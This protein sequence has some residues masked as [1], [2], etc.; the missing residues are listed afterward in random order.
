[1]T[2]KKSDR[3]PSN[4]R[5]LNISM[6]GPKVGKARLAAADLAEII[7]QTQRALK[8][9]GQV[10]YGESS[11]GKGRKRR[12][13][14]E[15]CELFLVGWHSGSAVAELELRETPA[16][17]SL[18]DSIGE[19][20]LNAFVNG[21]DVIAKGSARGSSLP[22]GFDPGVLQTCDA[23]GKVL[24]H[25]VETIR[26]EARN[27]HPVS[28]ITFDAPLWTKVRELLGQSVDVSSVTKTGR[29][30]ELN[31]HGALTGKLWEPDGTK[32]VCYFKPEH[33]DLLSD[34]WMRSVKLAGQAII[35]EGKEHT[36]NVESLIVLEKELADVSGSTLA[37]PFWKSLSLEELAD[38]QGV[39][40]ITDLN[41]LSALWPADDDADALLAHVLSERRARGNIADQGD[42][43]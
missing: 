12:D 13:I 35:E 25:G 2:S 28:T 21:M 37:A 39:A 15:L 24:D 43:H 17:Q 42:G 14:E 31:G 16:Q 10:L 38:Q 26:F 29:L 1:M 3:T 8:R 41:E 5:R 27:G 34:A 22:P 6:A 4:T 9:V 30:E 40:T 33:L 18:F 11:T 7:Q 36:L 32:W 23:L 20:S 19:D